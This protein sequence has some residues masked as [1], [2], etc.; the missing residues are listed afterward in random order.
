M[1]LMYIDQKIVRMEMFDMARTCGNCYYCAENGLDL[2]CVNKDSE[3]VSDFV[4]EDH[5]CVDWSG[6]ES[7]DSDDE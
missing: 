1:D 4:S 7:Q 5:S 6:S 2:A 3:Y